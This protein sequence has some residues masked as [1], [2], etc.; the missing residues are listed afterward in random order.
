MQPLFVD[1]LIEARKNAQNTA[2]A[3]A[4]LNDYGVEQQPCVLWVSHDLEQL[5]RR[6]DPI[7]VLERNRLAAMD[8]APALKAIRPG[9][10]AHP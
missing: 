9:G 4:L 3:E 6:C 1:V 8:P 7:L 2:A 5:R 10:K